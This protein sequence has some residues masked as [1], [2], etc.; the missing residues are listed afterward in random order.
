MDSNINLINKTKN[1]IVYKCKG[2]NTYHLQFNNL[3]FNFSDEEYFYFSTYVQQIDI[4][5]YEN[6]ICN[7]LQNRIIQLPIGHKSLKISLSVSELHELKALFKHNIRNNY[8]TLTLD[9]IHYSLY[10]N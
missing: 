3:S 2:C 10:F 6:T 8:K 7:S 1:G 9:K 4:T 5:Y